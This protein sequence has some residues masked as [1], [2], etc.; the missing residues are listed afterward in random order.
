M[1]IGQT[2]EAF[3]RAT[4]VLSP[5]GNAALLMLA[6][7]PDKPG[8]KGSSYE[9]FSETLAALWRLADTAEREE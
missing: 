8:E 7:T 9:A 3:I 5:V 1:K 6:T 4:S 2:A